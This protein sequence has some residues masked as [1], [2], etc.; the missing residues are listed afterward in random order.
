LALFGEKYGDAVRVVEVGDY[1]RELCGGTHAARSGQLGMVKLLSEGSIGSGVRR[2]EGLV[3]LDAYRYLA[4]EHVLL[5]Q[6]AGALKVPAEEVPDRVA[7]TVERLRDAEKELAQLRAGQVLER[8]GEYAAGVRDV[9]GFGFVG[10]RAPDGTPGDLLRQLA[11]DVRGRL[12]QDRPSAVVVLA[13]GERVSV[14]AAV[15]PAG[16]ARGLSAN[17]LLRAAA[18]PVGGK[19]GGK[20]DLAQ[21]GGSNAA[22]IDEALREAEHLVGRVATS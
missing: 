11:V 5:A 7:A 14:V 17:E 19:G 16:R 15:N 21:G 13:G 22:G 6:L 10:V 18:G 9:F 8:A 12:P 1:A 4:K 20:E 3:G 2:V